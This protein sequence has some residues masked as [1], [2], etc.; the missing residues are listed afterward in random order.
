M[1]SA[2]AVA[3]S[4]G[5]RVGPAVRR[6]R[7]RR[8]LRAIMDIAERNGILPA[9]WY[10]VSVHSSGSEPGFDEL[11]RSVGLI[12]GRLSEQLATTVDAVA[13]PGNQSSGI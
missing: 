7:V 9:G 12:L 4:I 2:G 1:P 11:E 3:Y 8:R 5:R 10:L 13:T 6:N